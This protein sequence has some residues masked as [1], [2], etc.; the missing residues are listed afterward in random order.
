MLTS[1]GTKGETLQKLNGN[2]TH[3][4]IDELVLFSVAAWQGRR[5][6]IVQDIRRSFP[7][8]SLA[9]RSSAKEEDTECASNA[10]HYRSV[11]N[12]VCDDSSIR[13][14]VEEV[15][16]SFD[17]DRDDNQVFIQRYITDATMSGV[18]T[19]CDISN[20][21]PYYII[22]Y[23]DFT[24]LTDTVTSGR[25]AH[26]K[27]FVAFKREVRTNDARFLEL[28]YAAH[29]LEVFFG[30]ECLDIEFI[31]THDGIHIVQVRPIVNA[32]PIDPDDVDQMHTILKTLSG[33][34]PELGRAHPDLH[35]RH[36]F[37]GVMTD[38]NP[39]EMIGI[40]P[41][42]LALSLYRELITDSIWA[43]QRDNYG[44]KRLRSFPLLVS[45]AGQ[46]FI[47]IRVDFN[48]YL[49]KEL[50]DSF[51]EK[52]AQYYLETLQSHP[53]SHDKVEFDI[54]FSCYTLD[55]EERLAVLRQHAFTI[56]DTSLLKQALLDLTVN[57]IGKDGLFQ[58]DMATIV[59]LE[60]RRNALLLSDQTLVSK[61]YWLVEDCKRYGTLPYAGIAR[62]AFIAVQFL[63]SMV[64]VG[65]LS[66]DDRSR[67]LRSFTT[68]AK[69]L[70]YDL[71]RV[72]NG[73]LSREECVERYGHLRPGT[74]DILSQ[75]YRENFDEYFDMN[76]LHR[77]E[78]IC[79]FIPSLEQLKKTD[80][81]LLEH[82]IPLSAAELFSFIKEAI[83]GREYAKFCFTKNVDAILK[84][85]KEFGV[86]IGMDVDSASYIEI[87]S[88]LKLYSRIGEEVNEH[89]LKVEA[90]RNREMYR[91]YSKI[92]FPELLYG[93]NEVFSFN[94]YSSEVNYITQ[95]TAMGETIRLTDMKEPN[96][97]RDKIVFLEN[98]D[99]GFDWIFSQGIRGFITMY[100][101]INSH[102]AI[103]AAEM[104]IPCA[105]GCG[106]LL[107]GQWSRART[108]ELDCLNKR[109]VVIQ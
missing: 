37:Y 99:P 23:D 109:V 25:G 67:F 85:V 28:C 10:G 52:L 72:G 2:I 48:S 64:K 30:H 22:N 97:V 103:R 54:V 60:K 71:A 59:H 36:T 106:E 8:L 4:I 44:Y 63:N 16:A 17:N 27:T 89:K 14:A 69:Q 61:V 57:I 41:R 51:S 18:I 53:S 7:G 86:I 32:N 56:E 13:V 107:Y 47:D 40:K 75:N 29:E 74:Y 88:I 24:G 77:P 46:P 3:G 70:S 84:C 43:Y 102:M 55:L 101:G 38:W 68:V 94:I 76:N 98:A 65:I 11:L 81:L 104:N 90:L 1:F 73:E 26:H 78:T 108:I 12:V 82:D 33:R 93:P 45:L 79:E 49:P 50:D 31:I 39:A 105:V 5:K 87:G 83:E 92:K 6:R 91:V 66:S 62:A 95:H 100:G 19:T 35:G 9:V 20:G 21:A 15:I 58:K 42:P 34:L 80:D 96:A